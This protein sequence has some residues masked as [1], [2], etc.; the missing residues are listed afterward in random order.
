MADKNITRS[1]RADRRR[2]RVRGKIHGTPERPRFTVTKSLNNIFAQI[3]DDDTAT[4]LVAAASNS[5]SVKEQ[6]KD[7][8]S[9]TEVATVVGAVV[10]AA[11]KEKGIEKVV[12]DRNTN[13]FHG[14]IKAA[15][16]SARKAGLQF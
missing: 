11:A 12:F 10:A 1:K 5:A 8:M 3:I 9:K 14:R 2:S 6:L 16:D 15:A 4:T 13:R 7:G